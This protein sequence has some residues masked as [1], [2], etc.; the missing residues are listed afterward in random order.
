ML[1]GPAIHVWDLRAIGR[2]LADLG[3]PWDARVYP[4]IA[5]PASA[6]DGVQRKSA[7]KPLQVIVDLDSAQQAQVYNEQ[8]WQWATRLLSQPGDAEE[9]VRLAQKAIELV[10]QE[11]NYWNTLGV[12]HYRARHWKKAIAALARSME[13]L[14]GRIESF[15]TFFLAMAHWHIGEKDKARQ[16]FRRAVQWMDKHRPDLE[17]DS[18]QQEELRRFRAEAAELLFGFGDI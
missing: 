4:P 1:D 16:W 15:N 13:L 6:G 3:L 8:A 17:K 14:D 2:R 10:P 7:A 12:A 11:G 9:A 5:I 18:E